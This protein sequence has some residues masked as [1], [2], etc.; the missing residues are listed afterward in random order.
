MAE[1]PGSGGRA[2]DAVGVGPAMGAPRR[3]VRVRAVAD[4]TRQR[5]AQKGYSW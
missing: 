4:Y 5:E 2:V 3:S 1:G